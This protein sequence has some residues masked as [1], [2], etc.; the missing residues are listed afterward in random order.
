MHF[1]D[2]GIDLEN[3]Q[4]SVGSDTVFSALMNVVN[5][6]YGSKKAGELIERFLDSPPFILTSFFIYNKDLHFLPKPMNDLFIPEEI[7]KAKGK[8]LKKLKWLEKRDFLR[9]QMQ[10]RLHVEDIDTM[11]KKQ[12][13]YKSAFVKEIR[14]RVVLDRATQQSSIYHC[15]Y[16]HF[17]QD[18]GLYGIVG[19]K[20]KNF[21][22]NFK[23]IFSL[24]G[25]TGIGGEKTYGCGMFEATFEPASGIFSDILKAQTDSYTLLSLYYP[26]NDEQVG[27]KNNLL[28]Y[29]IIRKKGWIAT[30]RSAL[31]LKRKSA[32]FITEGSVLKNAVKGG[33]IDVTPDNPP[34]DILT[35]KV[36][37]YG[38]AFT[39]P[40]REAHQ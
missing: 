16:I 32:G 31:P 36:Y 2:T 3:V 5:I 38:Y 11:L 37:R 25:Q 34:P 40:L 14:P 7:K 4:E 12:G 26:A 23:K 28:A 17:R 24:L 9:W 35:H 22:D 1:G 8:E 20:D 27:L 18:A 10:Y 19:F 15:G 29:D 30:G 33:L 21:V 13:K 6:Y 39:M